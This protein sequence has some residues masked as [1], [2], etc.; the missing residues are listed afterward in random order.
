MFTGIV[1]AVGAVRK[2][3]LSRGGRRIA[4]DAGRLGLSGVAKG[5]SIAVNGVCLTVVARKGRSF[6]VDVSRET[7]SCT[8]GWSIGARV[9][10]EK[11]MRA[12]DRLGGHFVVGPQADAGH[13]EIALDARAAG[14]RD[15]HAVHAG[16]HPRD[17]IAQPEASGHRVELDSPR[18]HVS[19]GESRRARVRSTVRCRLLAVRC[20]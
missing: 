3:A 18:R 9:N 16:L 15:A 17:A 5:D 6:E 11:A 20:R 2:S 13:E 8:T 4:V 7:L 14:Q 10:L 19:G 1:A 12:A